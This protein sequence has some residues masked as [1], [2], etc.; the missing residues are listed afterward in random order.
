VMATMRRASRMAPSQSPGR[1]IFSPAAAG[2]KS[3]WLAPRDAGTL[4]CPSVRK[5]TWSLSVLF[6]LVSEL[7]KARPV[8]GSPSE[9]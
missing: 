7:G 3:A 2:G 4:G 5:C 8:V 1:P 9:P 6:P